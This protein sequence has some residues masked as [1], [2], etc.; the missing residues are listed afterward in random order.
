MASETLIRTA[1]QLAKQLGANTSKFLGT[2]SNV[3]FLGS[4]PKDG[5]L[6]QQSINPES[7]ATIGIKKVLPDI[8][9][10]MAYLT[11][12]KLNDIQANK[13]IDNMSIMADMMDPLAA[14]NVVDASSKFRGGL[15]SL[16]GL[17]LK[18]LDNVR[19]KSGLG[20]RQAVASQDVRP[21]NRSGELTSVADEAGQSGMSYAIKNPANI[22]EEVSPLMSKLENRIG[23]MRDETEAATGI[24]ASVAKG[25]LPAKTGAAREFLV[26]SL[27]VGDDYPS[28]TLSDVMSAEDMKYIF[29]GGG[30]AMG[31][32]LVLVQKYFGPRI[33]EMI[34]NGGTTEEIAIFTKRV[35]EN[36]EDAKGLKPDE[37]GFDAM[38]AKFVD[39]LADG[40]IAGLDTRQGLKFGGK[41]AKAILSKID[42]TMIK[43]AADDIFPTDDYKY[44]AELVVDALV[45]NNPKLF[46]NLL[47]DD[48]DD[49]LRSE[50]YGLAVSE[51]G[52]RAAMKIKAGKM[53]RP[54][55]D[56]NG[57]LNKDAVLADATKFSGL[58]GKQPSGF[59]KKGGEITSENFGNSQFAPKPS[60]QLNVEKAVSDLNIPR[61]EAIRIAQL[62]SD[63]QM[64]AL[65]K[66]MDMDTAQRAELMNYNPKTFDAA[67]GGLAKILE[68]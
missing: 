14:K 42:E 45:E 16:E 57:N 47:A 55:F 33:A 49:A 18:N 38:T 12:G 56:E 60:F 68:L 34:P 54:L 40:G 64:L 8:E 59:I 30:G 61:E 28:T 39:Q 36:V 63:Q 27:K 23:G 3:S 26:N 10:S 41:A 1:L 52:T 50:L 15:E 67:K 31:D 37:Q 20:E 2:K 5:M 24:M 22:P 11:G 66:Y 25:D 46:K 13:L 32:P 4:G 29:E 17:G 44:D 65:Q 62:P 58:D 43:K 7:F 48:L 19:A 6:F 35:M 51:T 21:I 53:E 9:S